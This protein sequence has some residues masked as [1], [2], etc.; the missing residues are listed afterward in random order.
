MS[1]RAEI[2]A[3]QIAAMKAGQNDT[4]VS[5]R[6]VWAAVRN[7]EIDKQHELTD[8]EVQAVI[9]R[10]VKQ[11]TDALGDFTRGG[12]EDLV[13]KTKTEITLLTQ[14]LPTPLSDDEIEAIVTETITATGASGAGDVG[15]VM[16]S[17]MKQVGKRADGDRV[18]QIVTRH[19]AR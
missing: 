19:L 7:E 13:A 9:A 10:Q 1:L 6:M 16:G 8:D 5:L 3:A 4:V 14:Y 11:L 17:V 15:R 2:Q 18:R 12:R